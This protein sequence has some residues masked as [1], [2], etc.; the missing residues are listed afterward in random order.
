MLSAV[1]LPADTILASPAPPSPGSVIPPRPRPSAAEESV[2]RL[3]SRPEPV[4]EP[5]TAIELDDDDILEASLIAPTPQAPP[6]P[7]PVPIL[8]A[9]VLGAL[10]ARCRYL[11]ADVRTSWQAAAAGARAL[12]K[13]LRARGV[14]VHLGD[15]SG[16]E[17]RVIGARGKGTEDLLGSTWTAEDPIVAIMLHRKAALTLKLDSRDSARLRAIGGQRAVSLVPLLDGPR[18]IAMVEIIDPDP[19][20]SRYVVSA[21]E[22]VLG[23][24]APFVTT[25]RVTPRR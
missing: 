11:L 17:L 9:G 1:R 16:T 25:K 20:H 21:G 5:E 4:P 2:V 8:G 12:Q 7:T 15:G 3:R 13:E 6:A 24:L 18:L 14:I 23:A 19:V 10:L 22:L